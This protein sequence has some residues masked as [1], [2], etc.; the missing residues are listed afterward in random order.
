MKAL[1]FQGIE[2]IAYEDVPDPKICD[3][4]DVIVKV[5]LCAICGSDLHVFH[6]R[7]QGLDC[8]STMGHEF[9]GEVVETGREVSQ[10][11][12]G[13]RVVSP[14]TTSC[15]SCFYCKSGLTARCEY[16]SLYGWVQ[17]GK[18]LHGVQ[19]EYVRTPH[20]DGTLFKLPEDVPSEVGLFLGDIMATGYFVADMAGIQ[21]SSEVCVVIGCGPVGL[22]AIAGAKELGAR[23]IYAVD[24]LP[25]RLQLAEHFGAIPLNP[26]VSDPISVIKQETSGRGAAAVM[27]VVGRKETA[28]LAYNLVRPGG[29]ISI[30]GVHTDPHFPFSPPEVYDKNLT[31][32]VGRCPARTYME[33]LLKLIRKGEYDFSSMITH[34]MPLS[35]GVKGYDIFSKRL[36]GCI[37]VL[38]EP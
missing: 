35:D 36:D 11:K 3:D 24:L 33:P 27:E 28:R 19:A 14:F 26:Q 1:T 13:D 31:I 2:S 23:K 6:G 4:R 30:A 37:K 17:D 38:L 25:E 20:A 5:D 34:R 29:T 12:V 21:T 7:E 22:M 15:G 16:G 10:F 18:G 8:G 9:I 32:R